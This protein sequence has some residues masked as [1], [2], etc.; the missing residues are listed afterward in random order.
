MGAP[1][2]IALLQ[3]QNSIAEKNPLQK[4]APEGRPLPG[5]VICLDAER[6]RQVAN[7]LRV[8]LGGAVSPISEFMGT[9]GRVASKTGLLQPAKR[10]DNGITHYLFSVPASDAITDSHMRAWEHF[11]ANTDAPA[12]AFFEDDAFVESSTTPQQAEA[13]I[14]GALAEI[15]GD[16]PC[17]L[18][19]LGHFESPTFVALHWL[20]GRL[21]PRKNE[22]AAR[23]TRAPETA[24]GAH[25][26]ILTRAGARRVLFEASFGGS[27]TLYSSDFYLQTLASQ[28][29]ISTR[30]L[31]ERLVFQT[32]TARKTGASFGD[33]SSSASSTSTSSKTAGWV[34]ALGVKIPT[35]HFPTVLCDVVL[36]N[37]DADKYVSAHYVMSF[38]V[39]RLFRLP[40]FSLTTGSFLLLFAMGAVVMCTAFLPAPRRKSACAVAAVL[41]ALVILPDLCLGVVS[42]TPF[43]NTIKALFHLII[44]CAPL[45]VMAVCAGVSASK[46]ALLQAG[47]SK[48]ASDKTV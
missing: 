40:A 15:S 30:V 12:C 9:D 7:T 29:I 39:V 2:E 38:E 43:V 23:F 27:Q 18:L 48:P 16:Y 25:A 11:L 26:Y 6:G 21:I 17:D 32:S 10:T 13:Q 8:S 36:G 31:H 33:E 19:L 41:F 22:S 45:V 3:P 46:A 24:T 37:V 4:T 42:S 1:L 44:L 20:I 28:N 14:R 34:K 5:F 47:S 35:T